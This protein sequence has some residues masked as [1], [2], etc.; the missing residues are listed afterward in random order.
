MHNGLH[1]LPGRSVHRKAAGGW[2][3]DWVQ[4]PRIM[5]GNYGEGSGLH[6]MSPLTGQTG[7]FT[8]LTWVMRI[9]NPDFTERNRYWN[10]EST[11]TNYLHAQSGSRSTVLDGFP[12]RIGMNGSDDFG[13]LQFSHGVIVEGRADHREYIIAGAL[14]GTAGTMKGTYRIWEWK[15]PT[16]SANDNGVGPEYPTA[17]MTLDGDYWGIGGHNYHV[18]AEWAYF[19]LAF[20]DD[21]S[22]YVDVQDPDVQAEMEGDPTDWTLFPTP[23]IWFQ[24]PASE[25][26]S[27]VNRGTGGDFYVN[28]GCE[29]KDAPR[30]TL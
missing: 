27:G 17:G 7:T 9:R 2:Q 1:S 19:W 25:W 28:A 24:G 26:N 12:V 29:F 13:N 11:L 18:Q 5:G 16:P 4:M 15:N 14:E 20:A 22:A 30:V 10:C 8:S 21:A 6:R 23:Q 3:P